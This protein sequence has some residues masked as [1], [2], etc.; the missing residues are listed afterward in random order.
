MKGKNRV[1]ILNIASTLLL[2]LISFLTAPIFAALL[3]TGSYGDLSVFN[4]WVSVGSIVT[5]LHTVTTIANARVEFSEEEQPKYQSAAMSLSLMFF[6]LCFGLVALLMGPVSRL[7]AMEPLLIVMIMITAFGTFGVNF[8]SQ[9]FTFEMKAGR[10]LAVS[11]ALA[12]VNLG[13]SLLFVLNMREE[14]R[15]YGRAFAQMLTYSVFAIPFC[16]V[17]LIKGRTFFEKRYWKLCLTLAV[18]VMLYGLTDLLLGH[19]DLVMLRSMDSSESSGIYGF[20]FQISG[21]V[22]SIFTAL[23][24]SWVAFF[25][26]DM[27]AGRRDVVLRQSKNYL[28]LYTVLACGFILLAPE[29]YKLLARQDYWPGIGLIPCMVASFYLNFLCT[30]PYNYECYHKKMPMISVVT[31]TSALV[32]IGLNYFFILRIGMY[33]AAIA[34]LLSRVFQFGAHHLYSRFVLGKADY[35]FTLKVLGPYA[36]GFGLVMALVILLPGGGILRWGIGAVLGIWE[37]LRIRKRRA[38]M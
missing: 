34:T 5:T 2:N 26:N 8:M 20:A 29:V 11:V 32:N 6:L 25:F 36:L 38:L 4:T 18:P 13:V 35:P 16:I 14:Q 22:F 21:V 7:L 1:V 24:T 31:I 30:F 23:N 33:G 3:A 19:S 15:L 37:L 12:V 10:N 9:K 17:V 28:E 27:K